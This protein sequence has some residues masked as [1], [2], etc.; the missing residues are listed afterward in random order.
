M[1]NA[2][3][4]IT[5]WF[6]ASRWLAKH[7]Y[8]IE[9]ISEQKTLWDAAQKPAAAPVATPKSVPASTTVVAPAPV[10]VKPVAAKT[11]TIAKK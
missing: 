8:G 1:D 11:T 9:Q 2:I 6:E 4:D 3:K 10:T 5:S 7:G